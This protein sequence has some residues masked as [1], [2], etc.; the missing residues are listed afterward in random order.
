VKD[1]VA[2]VQLGEADAGI[3]YLT[4][5]TASARAAVK[6][7]DIP[8]QFNVV[9]SYPAAVVKGSANEAS[10]RAFIDYLV[11]PDG[12][13][14]LAKYG[15][16]PAPAPVAVSASV[17]GAGGTG[18]VA[19]TGQ[20]EQPATLT[21]A[22]LR[23]LPQETVKVTFASSAGTETHIFTGVRLANVIQQAKL[24]VDANRKNDKLRK[25]VVATGRDGY[26]VIVAWGEIDSDFAN[27]PVLLAW[28]DNG[29]PLSAQDGPVRLV[30]PTDSHG[31][32]YVSGLARLDVRDAGT[33][34]AP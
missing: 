7:I 13:Q 28:Q 23:K 25:Y 15:F 32:R 19:L 5:V 17:S 18:N 9:A 10:A 12:Q 3:V 24:R 2:K 22:D 27:A 31:G 16:A 14:V 20:V 6:A 34:T 21:V 1:V 33:T 29:Q 8:D 11:S 4:D 26:E 30:V